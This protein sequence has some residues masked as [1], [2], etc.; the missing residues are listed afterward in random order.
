MTAVRAAVGKEHGYTLKV[1]RF[2][3]LGHAPRAAHL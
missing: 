2:V 3:A 1:E